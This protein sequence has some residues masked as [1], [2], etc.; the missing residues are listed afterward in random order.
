MAADLD[1][2][3]AAARREARAIRAGLVAPGASLALIENFPLE[4]ARL[5]PAAGYWPFGG[6]IDP[7]PLMAAL[8]KAGLTIALPRMEARDSHP[9]FLVWE[10]AG[11]LKPDAYGMLAPPSHAREVTPKMV[12]TPLLAFDRAGRRLGQG[13]G[14]YDRTLA[15]LKPQGA[16]AVGIAFSAQEMPDLPEGPLDQRLDW[17]V[18]EKEAIRCGGAAGLRGR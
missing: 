11:A 3:K 8:A 5:G 13:G 18:T 12:L 2:D 4:L 6:E 15:W 7:R 10:D 1:A 16:I 9:R 14:H 17:V